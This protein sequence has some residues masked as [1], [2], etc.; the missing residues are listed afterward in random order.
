MDSRRQIEPHLSQFSEAISV[1]PGKSPLNF[2]FDFFTALVL[3]DSQ[4]TVAR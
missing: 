1:V 3:H 2:A 4:T